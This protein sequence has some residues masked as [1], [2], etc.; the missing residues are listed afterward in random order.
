V[1]FPTDD[2]IR[3]VLTQA[4]RAIGQYM[5]LLDQ[6][7]EM[8]GNEGAESVAKDR[9]VVAGIEMAISRAHS[10][11][12]HGELL[13]RQARWHATLLHPFSLGY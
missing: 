4:D 7:A 3:L 8:L 13:F 6:E 2:E 11:P 12:V 10:T 9:E 1:N 5:P